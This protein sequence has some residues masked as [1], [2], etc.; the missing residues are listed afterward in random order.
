MCGIIGC[1]GRMSARQILLD[2][3]AR[4]E[5]RG[6]DSA[7]I[8]LAGPTG[9]S[10]V[11]TIHKVDA[12]K[13]KAAALPDGCAGIGHTRWATHGAVNEQNA[14]PHR[15]GRVTL[16]HNGIIE[17]YDELRRELEVDGLVPQS[18]TDTEIAAML[19]DRLYQSDPV[20]AIHEATRRMRGAYTFAVLFEDRPDRIYAIHRQSPLTV[21]RVDGESLLASDVSALLPYGR[22]Y[23]VPEDGAVCELS[24]S[25]IR[26]VGSDGRERALVEM[27]A[28]WDG[29]AA[30]KNGYAH[31]ML[32]EIEEQPEVLRRTIGRYAREGRVDFSTERVDAAIFEGVRRVYLLGCGTA[33]H[34]GLTARPFLEECAGVAVEVEI[35][36]EF[37]DRAARVDPDGLYV[38]ISQSGE[39]ADTLAALRRVRAAGARHIAV[40]NAH[41][42]A[43]ERESANVIHTQAGPEISVASTKA[44]TAQVAV[45]YLIALKLADAPVGALCR[46]GDLA[47]E[48]IAA[49]GAAFE[50]AVRLRDVRNMFYLGRGAD[51]ALAQ[52]GA[53]KIKEISYLHAEAYAAGEMKHGVISLVEPGVPTVMLD[54]RPEGHEKALLCAREIRARGGE[55]IYITMEGWPVDDESADWVLRLPGPGGAMAVFPAAV[56]LQL[57]AYECARLR[58]LPIDQPRN[59]AK[60]VTVA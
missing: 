39:T 49:K 19:I 57:I 40:I 24:A 41:G 17:N 20:T 18:Q 26:C 13:R 44:F 42:T 3:L 35:A 53:L 34:A 48:A 23:A 47:A 7:G 5:Y 36:S 43:M 55:V 51:M 22:R 58:G 27:R 31:Y 32:K 60:S 11:K 37:L 25:G 9:I 33:M 6:Y 50:A 28:D 10:V 52:E 29:A 54:T 12:L 16:V 59:L 4:L 1:A 38:L 56:C 8:A 15:W 45:L 2:G 14:H 30:G 46:A 21:M